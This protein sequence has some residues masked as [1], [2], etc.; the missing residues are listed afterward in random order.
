LLTEKYRPKSLK[1]IVGQE[2]VVSALNKFKSRK[3][4]EIP[5][6]LFHGKPGIGKTATAVAFAKELDADY[7]EFNAS[8]QRTLNDI[9]NH[10]IP[11]LRHSFRR[12]KVI[13][14]DEVDR[15]VNE[16]QSA[17]RRPLEQ[18]NKPTVI[19]SCNDIGQILLPIRSRLMEFEFEPIEEQKV[20]EHL[21]EI[22]SKEGLEDNIDYRSI[23]KQTEGDL[24]AAI[25][26]LEKQS[27]TELD[28]FEEVAEK[29]IEA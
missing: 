13:F 9:R 17:L 24:R 18:Y 5:H 6:F 8:D 15:M 10:I 12:Q 21:K 29:Y 2:E 25:N 28:R 3:P 20:I 11:A 14:L 27:L 26:L 4:K 19:F 22:A 7:V 1:G 16:A 23:A